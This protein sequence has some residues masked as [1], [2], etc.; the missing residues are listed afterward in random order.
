MKSGY[1][2]TEFWVTAL[3]IAGLVASSV[4]A[5]LSPRYAA[6]GVAV[7][8]AAYAISRGLSKMFPPK[9]SV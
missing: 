8:S 3:S 5:S 4:A 6:M 7:S 1:K 9:N 2:T